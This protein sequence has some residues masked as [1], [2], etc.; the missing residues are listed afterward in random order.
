MQ[1]DD[2]PRKSRK[3]GIV[4]KFD[5]CQ[6]N[7]MELTK[8]QGNVRKVSQKISCQREQFIANVTFGAALMFSRLFQATVYRPITDVPAEEPNIIMVYW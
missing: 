5:S 2:L 7:V 6:G 1:G 4:R 3:P 8:T